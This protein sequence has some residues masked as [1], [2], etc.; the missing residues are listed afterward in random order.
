MK[1]IVNNMSAIIFALLCY[2]LVS[3]GS[4]N[5]TAEFSLVFATLA[6]IILTLTNTKN[7]FN[8]LNRDHYILFYLLI[9]YVGIGIL[10]YFTHEVTPDR[11]LNRIGTSLHF[12]LIIF[13]ILALR[14][15]R[16]SKKIFW[17]SIILGSIIN[18]IVALY[19]SQHLGIRAHGGINPIIFG[20]ISLLLGFMSAISYSFFKKSRFRLL[21]PLTGFVCGIGASIL[22]GS[23]GGWVA[24]P[25]L[26]ATTLTYLYYQKKIYTKQVIMIFSLSVLLISIAFYLGW[27]VSASR[28]EQAFQQFNAY[29]APDNRDIHNSVGGRLELWRGAI[30]LLKDYPL[31]GSGM[32]GW[33]DA[34]AI[35]FAEGRMLD[36]S[37]Y[38][39]I[40]N[41][42]LQEGVN[43]G[44]V[45][46]ASYLALNIYLFY[47]FFSNIKKKSHNH[48]I[49]LVGLLLVVGYFIFGLTNIVFNHGTFNTFF[50]AMLALIFT[51]TESVKN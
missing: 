8:S 6:A 15:Y 19:Q 12:V 42:I 5:P 28:I 11:T 34:F 46:I 7:I 33:K 37:Y 17:L 25:F 47:Y 51:F 16:I 39:N 13:S 20:D 38:G 4:I 9:V 1:N 14:Q 30:L 40:H 26:I 43:K 50:V 32:G 27:D 24:I 36:T 45:G 18:G 44:L 48:E 23:R 29:F 10:T 3:V 2:V 35:Q 41:Q 22:S 49:H 21:L 31:L